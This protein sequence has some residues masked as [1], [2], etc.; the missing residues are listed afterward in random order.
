MRASNR[1]SVELGM[2][3]QRRGVLIVE[4][5]AGWCGRVGRRRTECCLRASG[6]Q[7][8]SLAGM[9]LWSS[10]SINDRQ[11]GGGV[12]AGACVGVGDI[13]GRGDGVRGRAGW[14]VVG[15]GVVAVVVGSVI[16]VGRLSGSELSIVELTGVA[17]VGVAFVMLEGVGGGGMGLKGVGGEEGVGGGVVV[18]VGSG[19]CRSEKSLAEFCL[20]AR[21]L[22]VRST[23]FRRG[24]EVEVG[25]VFFG[26]AVGKVGWC[27]VRKGLGV[28]DI[29]NF[30]SK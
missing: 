22:R 8:A 16:S 6:V 11:I 28:D 15:C 30:S 21:A 20:L 14:V 26:C 10:R 13:S 5:Y 1:S 18:V 25:G 7:T 24:A 4:W 23:G 2:V 29:G 17:L 3:G 19:G 9:M 12:L 27:G